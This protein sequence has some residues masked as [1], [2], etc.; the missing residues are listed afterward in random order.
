METH[1]DQALTGQ[2][3]LLLHSGT[4]AISQCVWLWTL[5]ERWNH[6]QQVTMLQVS[7]K[8]LAGCALRKWLELN[9]GLLGLGP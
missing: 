3:L 2:L 1:L 4:A 8:V 5:Q 6:V 9:P 7:W